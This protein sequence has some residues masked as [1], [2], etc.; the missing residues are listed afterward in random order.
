MLLK[1]IANLDGRLWYKFVKA[2][3]K[4]PDVKASGFVFGSGLL[5]TFEFDTILNH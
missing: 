1:G 5:V 4:E 2:T 3:R